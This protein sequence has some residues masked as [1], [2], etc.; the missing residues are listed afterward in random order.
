MLFLILFFPIISLAEIIPLQ[1]EYMVPTNSK[2][3]MNL[4]TF[5]LKNYQ[6]ETFADNK[7]IMQFELP[8]NMT[9][10]S[11]TTYYL[12][13]VGKIND[14]KV[15][16]GS[17]AKATCDGPWKNMK[18]SL[19]FEQIDFDRTAL[20]D[21]LKKEDNLDVAQRKM[22]ILERFSTDPIGVAIVR[23]K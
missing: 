21:I 11:G 2:E 19:S 17:Q 8:K 7:A 1:A 20:L 18:C 23:E 13:L 16:S 3:E 10:K 14:T 6:V 5:Q 12:E 9:G 22:Q 15:L 4:N